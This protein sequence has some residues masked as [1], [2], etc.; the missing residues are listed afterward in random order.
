MEKPSEAA[1]AV[2]GTKE[3]GLV[4]G[5]DVEAK[6]V[7]SLLQGEAEKEFYVSLACFYL[8]ISFEWVTLSILLLQSNTNIEMN[9]TTTDS[10]SDLFMVLYKKWLAN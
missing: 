10:T 5:E 9:S 4:L 2:E 6:G 3:G 8:R 7:V 1:D